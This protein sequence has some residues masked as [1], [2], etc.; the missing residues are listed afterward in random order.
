MVKVSDLVA[1]FLKNKKIKTVFGIIGS[2]NSHIFDSIHNL[3]YTT[4]IN[5]HH[6]QA[7]VMAMGAHFRA[8][9][10]L[11]VAIVTAG[12]GSSNAVT[13]VVSNWADSIP[14]F[15][16]SG[17]ESSYHIKE[18]ET[19]RMYG[20]QGFNISKMV[21][22]VTKYS[23][24]LMDENNIQLELEKCFDITM[25]DRKGPTWLDIPFDIQ[26]KKITKQSWNPSK[27]P[28]N[29]QTN[30][31]KYIIDAINN[32]K[33]PL[34][35]GGHGI[36]LSNSK[37]EF[38]NLISLSSLPTTLTWSSIDLMDNEN[39]NFFGRFGLYGQRG[40]NYIVQ[41]CD[42][43]IVLGSRLSLPQTG[44]NW[45]EFVRDGRIICIDIAELQAPKEFIDL[46]IKENVSVVIDQLLN[47]IQDINPI[48][49]KWLE[50]CNNKRQNYSWIGEEHNHK[51]NYTNSYKF[52]DKLSDHLKDDHIIVTDM[53]TALLSGHQAL[54]LKKNQK[55]FTSNGLGEM[56]YGIA[57]ALG[58]AAACPNKDV[59]CLN[60]DGGIM[61]NLQELHTVIENG[62]NV[63]I[64]IFNND[65]YL[66]IKHTQK[67][68]FNGK[69]VSVDKNTGIGLPNYS[70]LFP[71]LGYK[72]FSLND[73]KNT[74]LSISNFLDH[75]GP[76]I[77][78]VFM[79][80]DQGFLPKVKGVPREDGSI[81]APPIEEM[82]P[83][84]SKEE[85]NREMII[86]LSEKSNE[87]K[88]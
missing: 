66:M 55:M 49:S 60:C 15:I 8:S 42:L 32:S 71:A 48:D 2:A 47:N 30:Y 13:G 6:E 19:L 22:D 61:M 46:H 79:D 51:G 38:N 23:H 87:I 24:C 53:G 67:M 86:K 50:Y 70:K 43:L 58:A 73:W 82:S 39:P 81:L 3:G 72:Y 16:I 83:L 63:K 75:N 85:L 40:A 45:D 80:P 64:I 52:M 9:G 29:N 4:I 18:H 33:R 34:V 31:S 76:S 36:R 11:S 62:L 77:L 37:N 28:I 17:N 59:L 5:T 84:V 74:D 68:L 10:E 7:A 69:Y 25:E 20:T 21:S 35:L 78:E 26:S 65:G 41:N 44:Y 88:R 56:G 1:E 54:K 27:P 57:G 14:G 12:G